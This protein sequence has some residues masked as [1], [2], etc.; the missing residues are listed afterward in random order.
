M[1]YF[2]SS[3]ASRTV[4]SSLLKANNNDKLY[5][6]FTPFRNSDF[7]NLFLIYDEFVEI[8][9]N[10]KRWESQENISR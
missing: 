4:L 6:G 8:D 1:I 10:R 7:G 3:L 2:E 9:L 5:L